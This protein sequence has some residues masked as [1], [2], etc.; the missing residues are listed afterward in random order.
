MPAIKTKDSTESK[1]TKL[2]AFYK[3]SE[4]KEKK[5]QKEQSQ[6]TQCAEKSKRQPNTLNE[7]QETLNP[8]EQQ[9]LEFQTMG[10]DWYILL[11]KEFSSEYF[12]KIKEFLETQNREG[13]VVYPQ[14]KDIYSWSQ[15]TP[16][17]Q[18]KVVILG[19]DPY[20]NINQAHG[21]AFSVLPGTQV[22]P[23]LQNIYKAINIDYPTQ[24]PKP[25]PK[26]GYL[27]NWAKQGVLLLNA[28]LTVEAHKANSHSTIGWN[29]FTDHIIELISKNHSNVVFMLWGSYAQKK[30]NSRIDKSRHLVL[31]AVHP[32]PLS[33][34]RGFFEAHHFLLANEYLRK[35]GRSEIEWHNI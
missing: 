33:A 21:L 19:Q 25:L 3:T 31:T 8:E 30:A 32:S 34:H 29:V 11:R 27:E 2:T 26:S 9:S 14:A 13:K 15:Y 10:R 20:H 5:Q 12:K 1:S 28:T 35:H 23:S 22:P 7:T 6:L 17:E 24:F 18:L 16:F 4:S